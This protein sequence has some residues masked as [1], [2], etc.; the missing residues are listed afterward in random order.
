MIAIVN[1]S[2]PPTK[3]GANKYE[4]RINKAVITTF[5]HKREDGMTMCLKLAADAVDKYKIAVVV[6]GVAMKIPFTN[7]KDLRGIE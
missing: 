7:F 1:V 4:V 2:T 5:E 3:K 6:D